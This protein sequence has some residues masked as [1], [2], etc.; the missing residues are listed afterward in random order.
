VTKPKA[1]SKTRPKT[2]A[3]PKTRPAA[4][5]KKRVAAKKPRAPKVPPLLPHDTPPDP[6]RHESAVAAIELSMPPLERAKSATESAIA[7]S[8]RA[9]TIEAAYEAWAELRAEH[10]AVTGALKQERQHLEE[11]GDFL[12]GAVKQARELTAT[13]TDALVKKNDGFDSMVTEAEQKLS[14]A[15][16]Q[17][18][19][20]EG[21]LTRAFSKG[22][23]EIKTEVRGR[24]ERTLSLVKP[25]VKLMVRSLAQGHRIV[26]L[27]RPAADEAPVLLWLFTRKIPTRYEFLFDDST[28]D[29]VQAPPNFYPDEELR[30]EEVHGGIAQ[31]RERLAGTRDALPVKGIIPLFL[32]RAS[33]PASLVRLVE[34]GPVM[35]AEIADGEG[36]RNLMTA[37]EAEALA[38]WLIKL[39]LEGRIEL[40][41]TR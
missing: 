35:E 8:K 20:R 26:H 38:G 3:R 19:E 10:Q 14:A 18:A 22:F 11:Q 41:L 27:G 28:D 33:G 2:K 12:L 21:A 24:L 30:A 16:Q 29:P 1:R 25:K 5:K 4:A 34:R 32:P 23:S 17:L 40:E 7:L 36:W 13:G 39:K 31:L 37:D 9:E 15:R 6:P